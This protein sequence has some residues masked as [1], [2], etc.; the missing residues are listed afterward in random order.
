MYRSPLPWMNPGWTTHRAPEAI[1]PA[2]TILEELNRFKQHGVKTFQAEDEIAAMASII[3]ASFA[4]A[5]AL[6][7]TSGPGLALKG[8]AMGLAVMMELPVVIINV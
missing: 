5:L 7:N 3:G 6:T 2:S 1:T 8:E 4:G